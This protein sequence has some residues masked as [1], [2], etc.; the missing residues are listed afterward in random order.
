VGS[1][2]FFNLAESWDRESN[3]PS[4]GRT[5]FGS[6]KLSRVNAMSRRIGVRLHS[7][8][9]SELPRHVYYEPIDDING[10]LRTEMENRGNLNLAIV[11]DAGHTVLTTN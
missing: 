6:H 2:H 5:A 4:D 8:L 3:A 11:H 10:Y 1:D 9:S 7:E